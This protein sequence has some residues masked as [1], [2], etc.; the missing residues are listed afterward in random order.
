MPSWKTTQ[1]QKKAAR[2]TKLALVILA[3]LV[4]LLLLSQAVKFTQVLFSPWKLANSPRNF[5]W[6]GD[7]NI[8]ILVRAGGISLVSFSPQNQ[9]LVVINIPDATFPE[10]AHGFGRW[11]MSSI[12]ELGHSPQEGA[13]FLKDT[14]TSFFAIPVEGFLD[15]SGQYAKQSASQIIDETR[16]NPF[17]LISI[18]PYLKTDLTPVELLRLQVGLF[19]LRFDKIKQVNLERSGLLEKLQL[20]DG[21]LVYTAEPPSLDSVVSDLSDPTLAQEKITIAIFNSTDH[22]QLGQRAAH[23][24]TNLGGNVITVLSGQKKFKTT[25]IV[26]QKSKTIERLSQIFASDAT[27][28]PQDPDLISS[29]AQI[30][31]FL[32]EDF[33][34]KL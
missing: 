28:D 7:F 12:Y 19:R 24:I 15:F 18:L 29:R 17:Y 23:L 31:I 16:K 14:V 3:L 11:Q 2:K 13:G 5:S 10:V 1:S 30:N 27:I 33:F 22:P 9:R 25:K 34:N 8:N 20:P 32:G 6:N 4:V 21:T 26:G